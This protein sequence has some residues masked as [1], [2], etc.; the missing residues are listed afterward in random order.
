MTNQPFGPFMFDPGSPNDVDR[1]VSLKIDALEERI[2]QIVRRIDIKGVPIV[3]HILHLT[4][5]PEDLQLIS[6]AL[7]R[8]SR[9]VPELEDLTK[10]K[11]VLETVRSNPHFLAAAFGDFSAD[12]DAIVAEP[13]P[14]Q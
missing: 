12:I 4:R 11:Q 8:V 7:D 9:I 1:D 2:S 6:K 14:E 13:T 10:K 5:D 3:G